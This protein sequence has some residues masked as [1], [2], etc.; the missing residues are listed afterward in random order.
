M[1]RLLFAA[2]LLGVSPA[3]ANDTMSQLGTGGLVF[4]TSE[5]V[6]MDSED[7]SVSSDQVKVVYQ[8]TN[9]SD[10]D[11]HALVAF[12]LPDITG[13]G[14]FMVAVPTEDAENI[15]G[16]STTFDGQPVDS[17]LHQ[18]A[19]AAGI[20]RTDLLNSL[21]VPLVPFGTATTEAL[22]ALSDDDKANLVHLGMVIPM[23]YDNGDGWKT[24]YTPV[25]TLKST[26]SWEAD[27]KA[28]ET[29]EV[30]HTYK[31]SVGGTVAVTFLGPANEDENRAADYKK[32]YCTDDGLI[33]TLK[34]Q[35]KAS[36]DYYSAPY[37][38]SW[39]SYIWSTGSNWSGPI[40]KFHLTV[41]KGDPKNLVS[42]CWDSEVNKTGPTTFEMEATDWYP[43][44]N[45]ELEILILNHQ[46]PDAGNAG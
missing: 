3:F 44:F 9:K 33:K 29:A 28:G 11:Q 16:F 17:T 38:E 26:Y 6:S 41:D 10:K 21:G 30:V 15:F 20:D 14:D 8:F 42:F 34:K 7:L 27:F 13:D 23:Q 22:N 2:L 40:G 46:E 37:T 19:F 39:I 45:R 18:Y 32:K 24:D 25:W 31:P 12:P 43:P 5:D 35:L 1:K 4:L 36:D